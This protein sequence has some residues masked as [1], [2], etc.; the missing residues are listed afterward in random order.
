MFEL[1]SAG[2]RLAFRVV[3]IMASAWF[4][5]LALG[6]ARCGC[7]AVTIGAGLAAGWLAGHLCPTKRLE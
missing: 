7:L 4:G 1:V 3:T 5:E 2:V 6:A